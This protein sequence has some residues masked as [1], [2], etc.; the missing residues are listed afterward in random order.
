MATENKLY[1]D[2]EKNIWRGYIADD[3]NLHYARLAGVTNGLFA[4]VIEPIWV[5]ERSE[6]GKDWLLIGQGRI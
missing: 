1:V 2:R 6:P 3:G 4:G 5:T